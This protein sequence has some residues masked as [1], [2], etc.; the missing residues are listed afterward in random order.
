MTEK[1]AVSSAPA[2][3][4]VLV[5]LAIVHYCLF[6]ILN[7]FL[8]AFV[9]ISHFGASD[10]PWVTLGGDTV[11]FGGALV[12]G[13]LA[14]GLKARSAPWFTA[15]VPSWGLS[16]LLVSSSAALALLLCLILSPGTS[17]R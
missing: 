5:A 13:A 8:A 1:S 14:F 11:A 3:G 2:L 17:F 6:L 16:Y 10:R 7:R 12:L 9:H 15:R 4:I